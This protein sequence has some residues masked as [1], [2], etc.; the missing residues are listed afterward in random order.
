MMVSPGLVIFDTG[1]QADL[2]AGM[3]VLAY[4]ASAASNVDSAREVERFTDMALLPALLGIDARGL[5]G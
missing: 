5:P 3:R 4:I 1:V 2:S